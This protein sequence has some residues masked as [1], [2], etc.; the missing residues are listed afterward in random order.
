[1]AFFRWVKFYLKKWFTYMGNH[2]PKPSPLYFA[3]S[4]AGLVGGG[5]LEGG[6]NPCPL[7]LASHPCDETLGVEIPRRWFKRHWSSIRVSC[8]SYIL[9]EIWIAEVVGIIEMFCQKDLR[10]NSLHVL[11]T[12]VSSL[13]IVLL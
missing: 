3:E 8:I 10:A 12:V 2:S 13:H 4:R 11:G 6:S 5:L 7:C 1:M 9:L